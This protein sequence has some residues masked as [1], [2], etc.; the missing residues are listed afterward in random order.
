MRERW[1]GVLSTLALLAF[2]SC[3]STVD[4]V[5]YNGAGGGGVRLRRVTPPATY[6]NPFRDLGHTDAEIA[7]RIADAFQKL[8]HG[9]PNSEAIYFPIDPDQ[10]NIQDF[11]HNRE[12]RTEGIGLGMMIAVQLDKRDEFDRLWRFATAVLQQKDGPRRGYFQSWCDTV[13]ATTTTC[14]DPYGASQML[15]AL[16]FAHDRWTSAG[17]VNYE[18]GAVALLDV[19]RHKEDQNGGIVD[20]VTNTFDVTTALP[21]HLPLEMYAGIGRPSVVMPAFYDLWREATDDPFWTRA[22]VAARAYLEKTSHP[23]TGLIPVRAGFDGAEVASWNNFDSES[24]RAQINMALD[25]AWAKGDKNAWEVT[26]ANR[27]LKFFTGKGME[28]YGSAY[29]LDGNVVVDPLRDFGLIACNGVTAMVAT[30]LNRASYVT[31]VW[32][33]PLQTGA[34]R[35]YSGILDLTALLILGGQYRVW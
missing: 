33:Q 32:D 3:S 25:W 15:T 12:T 7:T 14:D 6:P 10:A 29:S 30:E 26:E 13:N 31:A 5:G 2:A 28:T 20:G 24:Y 22:A 1:P 23:N 8:F 35:Y 9:D 27:L 34:A 17:A 11:L 21:F 19:M 4:S 16:I 18:A